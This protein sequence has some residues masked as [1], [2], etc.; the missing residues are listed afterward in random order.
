M[1][2]ATQSDLFGDAQL[3]LFGEPARQVYVPDPRHVRNRL[4]EMISVMRSSE[5]WPWEPDIVEFYRETVWPYLYGKLPDRD[6]AARWR[7]AIEA[8]TARLDAT[9]T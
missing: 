9:T 2:H 7:V 6:E 8:E 3:D 1:A 4:E 5:A